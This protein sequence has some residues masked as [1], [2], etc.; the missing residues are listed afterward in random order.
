[1]KQATNLMHAVYYQNKPNVKY[2]S[3]TTVINMVAFRSSAEKNQSSNKRTRDPSESSSSES[4]SGGLT[5]DAGSDETQDLDTPP[6][7]G[8]LI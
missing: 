5:D 7:R 1:M 3:A 4:S 6:R 8:R 2:V